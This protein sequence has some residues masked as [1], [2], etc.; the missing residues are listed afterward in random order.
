MDTEALFDI[1]C[2]VRHHSFHVQYGLPLSSKS[3]ISLK[4]QSHEYYARNEHDSKYS[5]G[6]RLVEFPIMPLI[7]R[8]YAQGAP[9]TLVLV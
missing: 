1:L 9:E 2:F 8:R 7:S 5:V 6:P 3:D 4:I